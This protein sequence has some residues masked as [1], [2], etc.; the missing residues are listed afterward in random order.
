MVRHPHAPRNRQSPLNIHE[1]S[2]APQGD[3]EGAY[4]CILAFPEVEEL[5]S[6]V[7]LASFIR[8]HSFRALLHELSS[9]Y[10]GSGFVQVLVL[11]QHSAIG[12]TGA[13]SCHIIVQTLYA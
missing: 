7:S 9:I 4:T 3:L 5:P 13:T 10:A 8:L 6:A 12:Q 1:A 11:P 2:I